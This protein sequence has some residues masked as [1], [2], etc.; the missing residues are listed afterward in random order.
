M[1]QRPASFVT[2]TADDA[3]S[4][5]WWK[6]Q[7]SGSG[8]PHIDADTA[9]AY[10]DIVN[11]VSSVFSERRMPRPPLRRMRCSRRP[12]MTVAGRATADL[13]LAW[14]QF[15]SGAVGYDSV[16]RSSPATRRSSS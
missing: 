12:G 14:L 7:Y 13:L 6:H 4:S 2:G 9:Q 1:R 11:A 15:A 5:G 3:E 16:V 10:L 8:S